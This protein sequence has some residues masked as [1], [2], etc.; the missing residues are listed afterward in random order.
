MYRIVLPVNANPDRARATA[1]AVIEL[2]NSPEDMEVV[3]LNV[4][5]DFDV[6][7]ESAQVDSTQFYD[8]SD[9][10]ES[11]QIATEILES[12]GISVTNRR[13]HGDPASMITAVADEIDAAIIAM[14]G[15]KR[16][17]TGKALFGSVLQSVLLSAS[18][19][20][21]VVMEE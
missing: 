21:H 8:E 4:F 12:E 13:E 15:R 17:P 7:D 9:Y 19:P 1:E 20:V 6:T 3:I 18:R 5:E 11:V 16:T 2:P 14:S 10:P